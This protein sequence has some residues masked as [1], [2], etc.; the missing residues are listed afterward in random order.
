MYMRYA[1]NL[2]LEEMSQITKQSKNT[3]AV[4]L[5]RGVEKFRI[6]YHKQLKKQN[7]EQTLRN[8]R[9]TSNFLHNEQERRYDKLLSHLYQ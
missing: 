3:I 8:R 2:S 5:H 6:L 9:V 7:K 1:E 4:Q